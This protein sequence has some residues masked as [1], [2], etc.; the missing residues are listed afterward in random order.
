MPIVI[1]DASPL[2]YLVLVGEA[3]VLHRLYGQVLVP[4]AV[5]EELQRGRTPTAVRSW[6]SDPPSWLEIVPRGLVVA[7]GLGLELLGD[8]EREAIALA[9]NRDA[10][11]LLMDDREGVE[12]ARCLG[13]TVTGTLGVLQR[14]AERRL[15]DLPEVIMR[16]QST[17][18]RASP[19][20]IRALLEQNASRKN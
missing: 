17:N 1:S 18:F 13:L 8:G 15:L 3:E 7:P 4:L 19:E 12:K 6:V 5:I 10:D 11:M 16:L 14:A 20:V 2:H 9:L